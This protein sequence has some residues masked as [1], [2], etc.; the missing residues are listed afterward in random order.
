MPS[1]LIVTSRFIR[2][3]TKKSK[4]RRYI[5]I[6]NIAAPELGDVYTITLGDR[7]TIKV[8]A[9]SYAEAVLR[10]YGSNENKTDLCEMVKSLYEYYE[11]A[12][13]YFEFLEG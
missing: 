8:S 4:A 10:T 7:G 3:D 5:E 12:S 6:Q 1:Q 11:K 13:H 9:L 2:S